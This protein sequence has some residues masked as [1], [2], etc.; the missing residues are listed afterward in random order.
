MHFKSQRFRKAEFL[1]LKAAFR[2]KYLSFM[3]DELE[4]LENLEFLFNN[5]QFFC[6]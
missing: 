3:S 5:W 6:V 2:E 1:G 4:F